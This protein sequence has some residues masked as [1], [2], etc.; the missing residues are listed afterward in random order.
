METVGPKIEDKLKVASIRINNH[1]HNLIN[2][3]EETQPGL[4]TS[5]PVKLKD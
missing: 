4:E 2:L 3:V 5:L 1:K